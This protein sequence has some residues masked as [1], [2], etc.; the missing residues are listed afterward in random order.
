MDSRTSLPGSSSRAKQTGVLSA[1]RG[2][3][4]SRA[5]LLDAIVVMVRG[6]R[7]VGEGEGMERPGSELG[8]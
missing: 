8:K 3:G 6:S 5:V 2:W 4:A 1:A 7:R